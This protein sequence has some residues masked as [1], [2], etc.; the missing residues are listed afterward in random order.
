MTVASINPTTG[1]TLETFAETTPTAL[2]RV[3]DQAL[4][5]YQSW[6]RCSYGQRA[7]AMREAGRLLRERKR[8][9]ARTMA[10]EMGKPLPHGEA[11]AGQCAW[12]CGYDG[13]HARPVR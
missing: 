1:E 7:Q 4:A 11:E 9:H 13:A 5:A 3:L 2:E 6:R 10:L 8:Q 12:P